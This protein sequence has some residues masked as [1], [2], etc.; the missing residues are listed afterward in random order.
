VI[1]LLEPM[2][3]IAHQDRVFFH[4]FQNTQP[5][6]GH[7][8]DIGHATAGKLIAQ[9]LAKLLKNKHVQ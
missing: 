7:W 9:E 5:A 3:E 6:T 8:N 4:G 1:D 2:Q